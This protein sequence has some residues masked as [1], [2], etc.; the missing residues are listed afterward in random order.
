VTPAAV[1]YA[2]ADQSASL[3]RTEAATIVDTTGR[4]EWD[5]FVAASP[6]GSVEQLWGWRGIFE[7]VFG[8]QSEYLTAHRAGRI[9]GALPLVRFRSA[10]FGRSLVSLP[11][12]N[13]AGLIAQDVAA[14]RSLVARAEEIGRE[15]GASHIELRGTA[16]CLP[17]LACRQHKVG[18]RL[19]LPASAEALWT[20]LDKKVRN[21]V[22]K[23]QKESLATECGGRELVDQFYPVFAR[24]M[25]DL[26]TPV[27]P[28]ALFTATLEMFGDLARVH[29]V[30]HGSTVVAGAIAL[31]WR[32]TVLVP[33]ASSLREYRHLCANM[34]LYWTM[35][36]SAAAG[37]Y[38]VFD[39]GR[40]TPGGGTH[41]FKQQWGAAD[42]PLHW[43]YG[44]LTRNDAPD[45]G[46]SNPRTKGLISAWQRLPLSLANVLGP[47]VIRHIP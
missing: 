11:Y 19:V 32:D 22:R 20:S 37:G 16:R 4:A 10:L 27:F 44:L 46:T 21:Q 31:S 15:F 13:Y 23:A 8:H 30:R 2:F 39:F 7:Q 1:L 9:V 5:A 43:E 42:F 28:K 25:R 6:E 36:E 12:A 33:W 45:H 40:S 26:G 24:N 41:L 3:D 14:A 35:L 38:H 47:R 17:E 34:L 29:L 18:A